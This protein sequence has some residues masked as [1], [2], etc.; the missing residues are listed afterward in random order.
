MSGKTSI[1][2]IIIILNYARAYVSIDT[3]ISHIA[4]GLAKS[5]LIIFGRANFKNYIPLPFSKNILYTLPKSDLYPFYS[6]YFVSNSCQERCPYNTEFIQYEEVKN[7]LNK[8][9]K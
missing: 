7:L 5:S 3:G 6:P 8:L 1:A 9:I 4:I 2:E